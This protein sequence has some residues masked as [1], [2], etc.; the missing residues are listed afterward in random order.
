MVT[1]SLAY[2]ISA[3]QDAMFTHYGFNTLA[4]NPAYAGSR[5]AL[6]IT[7]LSRVQWVGFEGAPSTHTLTMHSPI[8]NEN[9]GVGLSVIKDEIG[10]MN[11]TSIAAD[12]AYTA[13]L[14][15]LLRLAFGLKSNL[16]FLRGDMLG[17]GQANDPVLMNGFESGAIANFGFGMYL[18]SEKW[19]LGV[20]SPELFEKEIKSSDFSNSSQSIL[21]QRHYFVMMGTVFNMTENG[22]IMLKPTSFVKMTKGAGLVAD[23]TALFIFDQEFELG[24]M[25]R[26]GDAIGL[27]AGYNINRQMRI[28][29]SFDWSSTNTTFK[30]N[31]GSHEIMIR[32][33]FIYKDD[34]RIRSPRYF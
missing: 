13:N 7:A 24:L 19:Y 31:A 28:G 1:L 34:R 11:N 2:P 20:S 33:D 18:R 12:F 14:T 32:Y 16:T 27:L 17:N 25:V 29:Y 6:T 23:V 5:E 15:R 9:L 3:Q 4:M 22:R 26:T 21:D 8:A 30:Y 10:P